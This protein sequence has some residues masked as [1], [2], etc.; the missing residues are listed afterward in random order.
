MPPADTT[1]PDSP[2][3]SPPEC[4]PYWLNDPAVRAVMMALG[5]EARQVRFVGGCVRNALMGLPS[6]DIDI[7]TAHPPEES[8][9]LLEAAGIKV[10]PTG[11]A[12]GTVTAIHQGRPFEIT[13]LRNDVETDGRHAVV[14]FTDDWAEDAGRRDFT[15]NAL[16]MDIEGEIL[17]PMQGREDAA[18]GRVRFV[19]EASRRIEEDALRILRFFRFQAQ[20]GRE[21]IDPDGLAACRDNTDRQAALS[22][23][24]V[25][26]EMLK[27]LG[28]PGAVPVIQTMIEAGILAPLFAEAPDADALERLVA[29]ENEAGIADADPLRRLA[30]ILN[31]E[32]A[33]A[34]A[35]LRL[36]NADR[37]R[38]LAMSTIRLDLPVAPGKLKEMLYRRGPARIVDAVLA[39]A[40]K[41]RLASSLVV[42]ALTTLKSWTAPKFPLR[43]ADL[44]KLG[45]APTPSVGRIL[46]EVET[47]WIS[48]EMRGDRALCLAWARQAIEME[49]KTT[50]TKNAETAAR[51]LMDAHGSNTAVEGFP[52]GCAPDSVEAAYAIQ[53]AAVT[54]SGESVGAW[55]VGPASDDFPETCAPIL[56][57][58][59]IQ[60]PAT[61]P[62]A[63]R[64]K[65]VE[66]EVAFRLA[67][68]L[69]ASEGPYT[70]E[71]ARAAVASAMV[72]IEVVE[73]RYAGWPVESRLWALADNQSNHALVVGPEIPLPDQATIEALTATLALGDTVKPADKGFPGG[74]PFAL[75][76]WLAGHVGTRAP[77]LAERGLKA[78]D[79]ITTGSWNG[80]DFAEAGM[81]V[82]ADY[83]GLGSAEISYA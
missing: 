64:I 14:A 16:Y 78:G 9:R 44:L 54:L 81:T 62:N 28:A 4:P 83:P 50:M 22:G 36:S 51:A 13:T 67:R 12:H 46:A 74:D 17:D 65:A 58:R 2:L 52:D 75:I 47:R 55:K 56:A 15:M 61:F 24:R 48:G 82:R 26:A 27:L 29:L 40:A 18:A 59:V 45:L 10:K 31:L 20:Y 1:R 33:D 66:C 73:T 79:I 39:T 25:R 53:D 37:D 5:G 7:A 3:G 63:L 80:V 76:A 60:T 41:Q 42:D 21:A 43:G 23:E 34:V 11:I 57:S 19:G 71:Q 38:V 6:T 77:A 35:R 30:V 70:S 68:D 49:W 69:P 8:T 32:D 72:A